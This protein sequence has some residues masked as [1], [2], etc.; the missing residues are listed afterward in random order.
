[1]INLSYNILAELW[2]TVISGYID[3]NPDYSFLWNLIGEKYES[4]FM[5]ILKKQH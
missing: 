4:Q 5:F 3:Q 2:S 1:M